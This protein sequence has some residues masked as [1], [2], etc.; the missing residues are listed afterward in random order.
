MGRI[1][2]ETGLREVWVGESPGMLRADGGSPMLREDGGGE[3]NGYRG[4]GAELNQNR[5]LSP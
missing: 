2:S 4:V 5:I 1:V 3:V